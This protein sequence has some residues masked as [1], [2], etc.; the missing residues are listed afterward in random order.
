MKLVNKLTLIGVATAALLLAGCGGDSASPAKAEMKEA[1]PV[2]TITEEELSYR[3]DPLYSE[4]KVMVPASKY[5]EAP[6]TTSTKI[7][8][9]FQDAPP[10]IPHDTTGMLPIKKSDNQ[11]I[12]CHMPDVAEGMGATPIP[13]SHFLNM[14]PNNKVINGTFHK[15][16]DNLKNQVSIKKQAELYQ[17]RFNCTQCHA[18]QSDAKLITENSFQANYL[19]KDGAHRSH[20]D[21][22]T[23][24]HLDT[25]GADSSV[26][27]ADIDNAN[28]PAGESVFKHH[29]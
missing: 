5:S 21:K 25:L 1:K 29:K 23:T 14:R 16:V 17:G 27:Q 3:N 28:S 15:Q 12:Q 4:D 24:D 18:P 26:T 13:P 2:P 7:D 22:V 11:C 8:R 10:M 9:A 19:S 20:W 6:A